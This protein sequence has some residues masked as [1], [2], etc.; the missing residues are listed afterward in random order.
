MWIWYKLYLFRYFNKRRNIFEAG[1]THLTGVF[2]FNNLISNFKN[3]FRR[4]LVNKSES[5][6]SWSRARVI[7]WL[8]R[9]ASCLKLNIL[10]KRIY[11][12]RHFFILEGAFS[13]QVDRPHFSS[14]FTQNRRPVDI[15][16]LIIKVWFLR[17][18][19]TLCRDAS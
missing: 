6:H 5:F 2:S 3:V 19:S 8:P 10:L 16:N 11:E 18:N 4:A 17:Y 1:L 13:K 12:V 14:R 9:L 7:V 15:L